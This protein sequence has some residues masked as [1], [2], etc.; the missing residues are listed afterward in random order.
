[1]TAENSKRIPTQPY[2]EQVEHWPATGRHILAHHDESS[3]V[4]YQAY[5]PS[6]ARY[7][8]AHGAFGGPDFSFSRMSWVKPNFLWMMY[9]SDWGTAE[10]QETVL[11]IRLSR[12]FFEKILGAAVP[13]SYEQG[14]RETHDEWQARL[15]SSEV[16]LQWDPDHD[17][18][19]GKLERRAIQL[20]LRGGV[21]RAYATTEIVEIIDMTAFI[22][23]QRGHVARAE[24]PHLRT[25][26]ETVYVPGDPGVGT[27]ISLDAPT[28]DH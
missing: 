15:R 19:G 11:G 12:T 27:R 10:G 3:V 25:P 14:S 20:G 16:R 6:I 18:L 26:V 28:F 22:D 7:A 5:R 21:L 1:V 4:V 17:P 23:E 24:W 13:S 9:R 8:L 2:L